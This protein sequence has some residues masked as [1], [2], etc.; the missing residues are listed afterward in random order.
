MKNQYLTWILIPLLWS[1]ST[2]E[3]KSEVVLNQDATI[4]VGGREPQAL[5]KGSRFNVD[6]Q[7]VLVEAPGHYSLLILPGASD[8]DSRTEVSLKAVSGWSSRDLNRELNR[9]LDTIVIGLNQ[10]QKLMAERNLRAALAVVSDLE[11]KYPEVL[12]IRM[13]HASCLVVAG[14]K[15]KARLLLQSVLAEQ[16][17]HREAKEFYRAIAGKR[18][19]P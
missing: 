18:S 15:E 10:V 11:A 12:S 1:C 9:N 5:A 13:V 6:R 19:D 3:R 2:L 7:P 16:P 17:E 14:E 4:S 8:S